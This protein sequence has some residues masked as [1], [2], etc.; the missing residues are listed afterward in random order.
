MKV[1]GIDPGLADTGV[2]VVEGAPGRVVSFSYG[3]IRTRPPLPDADRLLVIHQRLTEILTSEAPSL[4]VVEEAYSLPRFPKSGLTLGKVL[5][6]VLLSCTKARV[7][8]AEV[9]VR[10]AK[11]VLT[12]NGAASKKQLE[13]AVRSHLNLDAPITPSH[14]SDAAALALLGLFRYCGRTGEPVCPRRRA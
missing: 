13:R 9:A 11:Q 5:G 8:V 12:G 1:M 7:P 2:A 10:E 14:A 6:V 3:T 4:L